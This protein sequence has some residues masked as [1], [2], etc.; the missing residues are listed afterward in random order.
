[1]VDEHS[2]HANGWRGVPVRLVMA[3]EQVFAGSTRGGPEVR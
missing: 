2:Q 3:D 1:M